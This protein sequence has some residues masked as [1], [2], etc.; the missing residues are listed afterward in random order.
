MI[1]FFQPNEKQCSKTPLKKGDEI[2]YST[3]PSE[4][5]A[6][7]KDGYEIFDPPTPVLNPDEVT[8]IKDILELHRRGV[9]VTYVGSRN[10]D[11]IDQRSDFAKLNSPNYESDKLYPSMTRVSAEFA[12]IC[13]QLQSE[14]DDI[15]QR[16]DNAEKLKQLQSSIPFVENSV[17]Q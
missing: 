14:A 8:R 17:E 9:N 13:P 3:L 4:I 6:Y 12:R 16:I 11:I 10:S 5:D 2:V 15:K 1:N 7:L